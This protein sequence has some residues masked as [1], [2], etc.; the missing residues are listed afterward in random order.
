MLGEATVALSLR[1]VCP[2]LQVYD[3][4]VAVRFYRDVLEFEVVSTSPAL[5]EPDDFHWVWLKGHGCELMLNTAYDTGLRP[6]VQDAER[7][8]AH[9]D[10]CLY[11]GCEDAD[12]A[13]A[14]LRAKGLILKDPKIAPYG[15]RQLYFKDPDGFGICFQHPV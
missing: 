7:V 6:E 3:M 8:R 9:G 1:G 10:T 11:F 14:A 5:G 4:P 15:M 13:C 12:A 2:L